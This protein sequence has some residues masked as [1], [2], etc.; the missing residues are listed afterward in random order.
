MPAGIARSIPDVSL[1][2]PEPGPARL[3]NN[4]N[5]TIRG[6]QGETALLALDMDGVEGSAGS[7]CTTGNSEPSHV[8]L[9]M[10]LSMPDAVGG[11]RLTLSEAN[12]EAELDE[13]IGALPPIVAK[14]RGSR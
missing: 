7:A 4:L 9:A 2:G 5:L 8:L 12:T 3:A 6:I 13:V 14:L 1:N 11:L 10:G